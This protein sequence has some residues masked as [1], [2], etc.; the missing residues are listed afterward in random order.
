MELIVVHITLECI[1]AVQGATT[2]EG[3]TEVLEVTLAVQGATTLEAVTAPTSSEMEDLVELEVMDMEETVVT[4]ALIL[5]LAT[6]TETTRAVEIWAMA[7]ILTSFKI[8]TLNLKVFPRVI[9]ATIRS[10]DL[11][12]SLCD[13]R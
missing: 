3:D 13:Y 7:I 1:L 5:T 12:V 4:M 11:V 10:C 9:V 8:V 6:I 2:Q